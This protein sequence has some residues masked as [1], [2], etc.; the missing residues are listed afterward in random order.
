MNC[1][2]D[3]IWHGDV[4]WPFDAVLAIIAS[5]IFLLY[6]FTVLTNC[7]PLLRSSETKQATAA[8]LVEFKLYLRCCT[9]DICV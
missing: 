4:I 9:R 8:S 6:L 5:S 3:L 7:T 1:Q 2:E